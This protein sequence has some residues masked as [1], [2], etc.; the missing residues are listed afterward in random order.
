MFSVHWLFELCPVIY[1]SNVNDFDFCD[2]RGDNS[3]LK[4]KEIKDG[5]EMGRDVVK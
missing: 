1:V 3:L 4:M 2:Q 5:K